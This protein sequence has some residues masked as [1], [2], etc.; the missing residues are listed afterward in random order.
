MTTHRRPL[1][2]AVA[3][4]AL[5]CPAC[6]F[7]PAQSTTISSSETRDKVAAQTTAKAAETARKDVFGELPSRPGEAVAIRHAP[8][9]FAPVGATPASPA[10]P[11]SPE[12]FNPNNDVKFATGFPDPLPSIVTAPFRPGQK[13]SPLLEAVRAHAEGK[14]G[15]AL[16]VL[17]T[18]DQPNQDF[19]LTVLPILARGATADLASDPAGV[20]VLVDQLET[21]AARLESRASLRIENL[22]FCGKVSGFG[23]YEPWPEGQPYHPN[24][25]AQLYLEVRNLLSQ[26]T[27][28][29]HGESH[30]THAKAAIEIKDAHGVLVKQPDPD[31]WR[32]RVDVAR[33]EKKLFS[34]GSIHDFH[35]LYPFPVPTTPGVYTVTVEIR[36]PS[37]RRVK[38]KPT[39]FRVTGP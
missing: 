35:I 13:D 12:P 31:D 19:I 8:K 7:I 37:G 20:A 21:A 26:P 25:Q 23:R 16:E 36:D 6:L 15:R 9:S 30:L 29:P 17:K 24:D 22:A 2:F 27:T 4:A 28:G 32:R 5:V 3:S 18:L 1:F 10:S 11:G 14:P 33:F 34:R 39:E 38:S